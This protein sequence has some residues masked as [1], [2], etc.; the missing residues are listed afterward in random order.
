MFNMTQCKIGDKLVTRGGEIVYY[1]GN[2]GHYKYPFDIG[3]DGAHLYSVTREGL[4]YDS[5]PLGRRNIV[6]FYSEPK[7]ELEPADNTPSISVRS[8]KR[9]FITIN[10]KEVEITLTEL[11]Q[12][13]SQ[14]YSM[15]EGK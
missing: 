9:Y 14:L 13:Y 8:E 4:E 7:P 12:L 11:R 3:M 10:N 6:G 15:L 5:N 1:S 2:D